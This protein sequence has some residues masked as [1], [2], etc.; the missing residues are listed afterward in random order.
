MDS[1][2]ASEEEGLASVPLQCGP[3][4]QGPFNGFRE[5]ELRDKPRRRP[6]ESGL[7]VRYSGYALQG[8]CLT[9]TGD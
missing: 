3:G 5:G 6:S 7:L 9:V 8:P 2:P 1:E 4:T